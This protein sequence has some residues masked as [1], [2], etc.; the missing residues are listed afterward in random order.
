MKR[1]LKRNTFYLLDAGDEKRIYDDETDSAKALETMV[2]QK[3]DIDTES[4]E[5]LRVNKVGEGWEIEPVP[6]SRIVIW[7]S[8][9]T[10]G[11]KTKPRLFNAEIRIRKSLF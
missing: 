6:W 4:L 8:V 2:S 11:K 9:K 3:D 1:K 5:M 10:R 7:E